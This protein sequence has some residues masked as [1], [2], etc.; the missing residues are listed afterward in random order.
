MT[1]MTTTTPTTTYN[2]SYTTYTNASP[3][4]FTKPTEFPSIFSYGPAVGC[5]SNSVAP[6]QSA[7][8]SSY[9]IGRPEGRNGGCV[10]SNDADINDHAFWDMYAC[11]SSNDSTASGSPFPC[12]AS[13][14]ITDGQSFL[15][16]GECLSKRVEIVI[17]SPPFDQIDG[18]STDPDAASSGSGSGTAAQS[19]PA[20]T[21]SESGSA[22]ASS[23]TSA[24]AS[25]SAADSTGAASAV[26]VT[27][28]ASS[29]V[30]LL[31]FGIMAF[32]SA[33]GML[34]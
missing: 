11:C 6:E 15:D 27:Q 23:D 18:N 17:C 13:C 29:K 12:T 5:A 10:I 34:L 20:G 31:L 21:M 7:Q 16:L 9:P 19:T 8:P 28:G 2:Y 3:S 30:G 22:S 4:P 1:S 33:A 24:S 14:S 25:T 26:G 32:G